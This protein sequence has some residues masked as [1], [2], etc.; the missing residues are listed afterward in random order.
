MQWDFANVCAILQ[1]GT[2]PEITH[3]RNGN[4][5]GKKWWLKTVVPA[6]AHNALTEIWNRLAHQH[7]QLVTWVLEAYDWRE[8]RITHAHSIWLRNDVDIVIDYQPPRFD[9]VIMPFEDSFNQSGQQLHQALAHRNNSDFKQ[10]Q[11]QDWH[12]LKNIANFMSTWTT[13][14]QADV[15]RNTWRVIESEQIDSQAHQGAQLDTK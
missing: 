3:F 7:P 4:H 10:N 9:Y 5:P 14:S 12:K 1:T 8:C 13:D 6:S 2:P 15:R 11:S